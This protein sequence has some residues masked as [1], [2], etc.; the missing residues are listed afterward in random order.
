[1]P[2]YY[3]ML[4]RMM[5]AMY[6]SLEVACSLLRVFCC[7]LLARCCVLQ[8]VL[9]AGAWISPP[10]V[11]PRAWG[12]GPTQARGVFTVHDMLYFTC[13]CVGGFEL[14]ARIAGF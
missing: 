10:L 4:L 3:L 7:S 11:P 14:L 6:E 5:Y 12:C 2:C 8:D 9:P 13:G 1:M